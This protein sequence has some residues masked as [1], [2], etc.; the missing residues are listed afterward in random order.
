MNTKQFIPAQDDS[1]CLYTADAVQNKLKKAIFLVYK[2]DFHLIDKKAHERAIAHRL[3]LYLE[4]FFRG[5]HVDCEYNLD[6]ND[7]KEILN[8]CDHCKGRHKCRKAIKTNDALKKVFPDIVIHIRGQQI[9]LLAI[10]MK[11]SNSQGCEK[12]DK[13][14]LDKY[15]KWLN[16]KCTAFIKFKKSRETTISSLDLKPEGEFYY[17]QNR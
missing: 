16:Y 15:K 11:K 4:D 9:N 5:W 14:K 12:Y 13:S 17:E 3:A 8:P 7:F 10:E 2:N 6:H 1:Q